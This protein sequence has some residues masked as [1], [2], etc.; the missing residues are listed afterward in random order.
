MIVEAQVTIRGSRQAAWA[1]IADIEGAAKILSGVQQIEIVS[2]PA[3]GLV[4]LRWRETRL[5]FDKPATVEKWITEA[6]PG[7][8]LTSR[9]EEQ[10]FAYVTTNR[11]GGSDGAVTITSSHESVPQRFTA[12]LMLVPMALFFKGMLRKAILQDLHDIQAAVE[13]G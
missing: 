9:A 10:G 11:L 5:L 8:F 4:G 12:R 3:A 1:A 13:R 2:R 6:A 7:E